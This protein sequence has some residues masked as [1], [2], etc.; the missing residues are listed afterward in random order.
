MP[1]QKG[2]SGNPSGKRKD[3]LM[4]DALRLEITQLKPDD[5][6]SARSIVRKL[7]E[8]AAG[9]EPWAMGEVFDR[10]DGKAVQ[11]INAEVKSG[12]AEL[13]IRWMKPQ[14]DDP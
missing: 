5:L 4:H 8:K 13:A 1:F 9:G 14:S 7:L 10:L 6:R 2:Q 3:K 11:A 12:P